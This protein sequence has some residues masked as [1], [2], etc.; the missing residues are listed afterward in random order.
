VAWTRPVWSDRPGEK[1]ASVTLAAQAVGCDRQNI[2]DV[3][4]NPARTCYGRHW[5]TRPPEWAVAAVAETERRRVAGIR[6]NP[7]RRGR[8][9]N[10]TDVRTGKV[11]VGGREVT[12]REG[13]TA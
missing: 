10:G 11:Y 8:V 2:S 9:L 6:C 3:L 7:G 13:V 1:F 5:T 12:E 4:D